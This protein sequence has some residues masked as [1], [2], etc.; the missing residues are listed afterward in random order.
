MNS[1]KRF[2]ATPAFIFSLLVFIL[3]FWGVGLLYRLNYVFWWYDVVAH[4][5]GGVWVALSVLAL[6]ERNL[7]SAN[8]LLV[9]GTVALVG[10]LWEFTE[11]VWDRYIFQSGFTYLSGV[12]EDTLSDLFFDLIGGLAAL[13][14]V[15]KNNA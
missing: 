1:A 6:K 2:L 7:I 9:L 13:I 3:V 11:F 15:R 14:I 5:L 12:Y 10:V 4:F 8:F